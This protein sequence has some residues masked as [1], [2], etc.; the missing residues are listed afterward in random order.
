MQGENKKLKEFHT[1]YNS[2]V[3]TDQIINNLAKS[4]LCL[5]RQQINQVKMLDIHYV[6]VA[7]NQASL[8]VSAYDKHNTTSFYIVGDFCESHNAYISKKIR[9]IVR[10]VD[11]IIGKNQ[12]NIINSIHKQIQ[13]NKYAKKVIR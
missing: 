2:C 4:V 6:S 10:R 5:T 3:I 7:L 1:K 12:Q 11:Y 8:T 9:A 13:D